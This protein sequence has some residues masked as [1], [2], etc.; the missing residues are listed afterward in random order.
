MDSSTT[1]FLRKDLIMKLTIKL[2][3]DV[4]VA[5]SFIGTFFLEFDN[6]TDLQHWHDDVEDVTKLEFAQSSSYRQMY[7]FTDGDDSPTYDERDGDIVLL[8]ENEEY[9][10]FTCEIANSSYNRLKEFIDKGIIEI[11]QNGFTTIFTYKQNSKNIVINKTLTFVSVINGTF[12]HTIGLKSI[13]I[14]IQD[15]ARDYNYIWIPSL[16]RY[17]YIDSVELISAD[18]TRLHLKEDVLMSWQ[19]LIKSQKAFITR[20]AEQN[21]LIVDERLPLE[22]LKTIEYITPTPTGS[23]S[24]VNIQLSATFSSEYNIMIT[25]YNDVYYTKQNVPSPD[26]NLPTLSPNQSNTQT[27]YFVTLSLYDSFTKALMNEDTMMASLGSILFLPFNPTTPFNT[28]TTAQTLAIG[29]PSSKVLCS[30][31]KFH[32]L[33]DIPSG[34]TTRQVRR[35][36]YG[37]SPYLV[38][39]DFTFPDTNDD[40]YNC[41]PYTYYEI[42]IAFVGWVKVDARQLSN[43]RVLIYYTLDLQT[44]NG[45]AFIYDKTDKKVI[46]SCGCQLGVKLDVISSNYL[47]LSR[48]KQA[49]QLNT[50]IGLL[51]SAVSIGAGVVTENPVAI[52]GGVLSAGKTIASAVN[53]ERMMFERAQVTFGSGDAGLHSTLATMIRKTYNK[54]LLSSDELGYY[55]EMQGYPRNTYDSLDELTGYTEIG[56][57]HFNPM[58]ESIYQDEIQEI[59]SLLNDGVIF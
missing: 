38:L 25:T 41:E 18:Y 30:D 48:E 43:K 54:H 33:Y 14:D 17:Y 2:N 29:L 26:T 21:T 51:A 19:D 55:Y 59:V 13:N 56:E 37:T 8:S 6:I 7:I 42:Y 52:A 28:G 16:N 46:Y 20:S 53:K 47:E 31:D 50:L 24:Q 39:A 9:I 4:L 22:S 36:P 35:T 3:L 23:G 10:I 5:T 57:I 40:W 49:N 45:T 15:Y 34:V 44:G 58:N 32:Y 27:T 12:N 1:L 11:I